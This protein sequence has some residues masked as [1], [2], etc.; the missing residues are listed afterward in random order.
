MDLLAGASD[1]DITSAR[2][3]AQA[4]RALERLVQHLA[5]LVGA[6]GVHALLARSAALSSSTSPWLANTIPPAPAADAESL[7]T[8]R[9]AMER[10]DPTAIRD[11]LS[12]L[13][14]N[15][16]WLLGRLIGAGLV[17]QLLHDVPPESFRTPPKEAT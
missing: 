11:G 6:R 15:F 10:Q 7:A 12:T 3:A 17:A 13:L 14:S 4:T 8:L 9:A 2:V 5:Q 16:V 1:D